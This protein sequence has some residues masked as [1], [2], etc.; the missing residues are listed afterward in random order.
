MERPRGQ[1]KTRGGY[2]VC[3]CHFFIKCYDIS[4]HSYFSTPSP[5]HGILPLMAARQGRGGRPRAV[6]TSAALR[7]QMILCN[8]PQAIAGWCKRHYE[9]EY[10][11]K[12]RDE[13]PACNNAPICIN[14]PVRRGFCRS[15]YDHDNALRR[16]QTTDDTAPRTMHRRF[17]HVRLTLDSV[18]EK[19]FAG[20]GESEDGCRNSPN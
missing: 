7:C 14:R 18:R 3:V 13:Q 17:S 19:I 10:R 15:C 11:L 1:R 5:S 12:R 16:G 20:H 2:F 9:I 8:K 4:L 6:F